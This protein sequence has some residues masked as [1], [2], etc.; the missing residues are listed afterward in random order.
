MVCFARRYWCCS[1]NGLSNFVELSPYGFWKGS[2]CQLCSSDQ[3]EKPFPTYQAIGS[4]RTVKQQ[5]SVGIDARSPDDYENSG[6][7]G[8]GGKT[9]GGGSYGYSHSHLVTVHQYRFQTQARF[10]IRLTVFLPISRCTRPRCIECSSAII[11]GVIVS[12]SSRSVP[13]IVILGGRVATAEGGWGANK[14]GDSFS[15]QVCTG[16]T[17]TAGSLDCADA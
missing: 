10:G 7:N 12:S 11:V 15:R 16:H 5:S 14:G 13:A 4:S 9:Q 17:Q 6:D 8:S 1:C 3:R 2:A